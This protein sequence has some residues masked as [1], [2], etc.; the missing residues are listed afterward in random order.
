MS[1]IRSG[2]RFPTRRALLIVACLT[3]G[4]AGAEEM[5]FASWPEVIAVIR[6]DRIARD[7]AGGLVVLGPIN[8]E[9]KHFSARAIASPFEGKEIRERC[10]QGGRHLHHHAYRPYYPYR[11]G[12]PYYYSPGAFLLPDQPGLEHASSAATAAK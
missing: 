10:F 8:I 4:Q 9:E 1:A 11:Y 5:R 12:R 2:H 3:L 6:C 7:E